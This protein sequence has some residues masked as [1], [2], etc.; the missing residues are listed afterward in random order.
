ML[1]ERLGLHPE[2]SGRGTD[3]GRDLYLTQMLSHPLKIHIRWLVSCKDYATGGKSVPPSDLPNPFDSTLKRH[4]TQ[5]FLLVTTTT[6]STNTK[7]ILDAEAD[8]GR[9]FTD[10]W[11][12]HRLRELLLKPANEDVL[13]QFFPQSYARIRALE[14]LPTDNIN[15]VVEQ[16]AYVTNPESRKPLLPGMVEPLPR[17]EVAHIEDQLEAGR[18]VLVTGESGSG[19]SGIAFALCT[20]RADPAMPILLLDARRY[21]NIS[22]LRSLADEIDLRDSVTACIERIGQRV[23]CRLIIDQLDS[24]SVDTAGQVFI[25]LA[26]QCSRLSRVQVVI[27]SRRRESYEREMLSQLMEAGFTELEC[28]NLTDDVVR[29]VLNRLDVAE[30]SDELTALSKNL[31]NLSLVARIRLEQPTYDFTSILDET[32]LW[33]GYVEALRSNEARH[34]RQGA[35]FGARIIDEAIRLAREGMTAED[36]TVELGVTKTPEQRRLESW[37]V[38]I[39]DEGYR[40]R[41]YHEKLQDFLYARDAVARGYMPGDVMS[42]LSEHRTHNVLPWMAKLYQRSHSPRWAEFLRRSLDV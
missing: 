35:N 33:E 4:N 41:F 39:P 29:D 5:G 2:W 17:P 42:E 38:I 14:G 31:L 8:G 1:T 19:K 34:A 15:R 32:A 18:L 37:R 36:R 7:D 30:P 28:G 40:Y 21:S 6:A 25:K 13:K 26:L 3:G 11:N 10:V 16:F 24:T 12:E 27:L 23:G 9:F 20:P 22:D